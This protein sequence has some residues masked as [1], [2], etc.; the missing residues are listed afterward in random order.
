MFCCPE[1]LSVLRTALRF[2]FLSAEQV[3]CSSA[4]CLYNTRKICI[5]SVREMR[6]VFQEKLQLPTFVLSVRP[7]VLVFV[8]SVLLTDSEYQ[9]V[10]PETQTPGISNQ[11]P[12]ELRSYDEHPKRNNVSRNGDLFENFKNNRDRCPPPGHPVSFMTTIKMFFLARLFLKLCQV[13]I[14]RN[15]EKRKVCEL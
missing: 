2:R 10:V 7:F 1:W 5:Y 15:V 8:L 3:E 4:R 11:T 13:N 6:R 14:R 9:L 12:P